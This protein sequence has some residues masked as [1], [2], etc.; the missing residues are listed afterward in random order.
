MFAKRHFENEVNSYH[1]TTVQ[2]LNRL[3]YKSGSPHFRKHLNSFPRKIKRFF[4]MTNV[5]CQKIDYLLL[6]QAVRCQE[7]G[8]FHSTTKATNWIRLH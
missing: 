2:L 6:L 1:V 8:D 3:S 4:H 5:K 7:I